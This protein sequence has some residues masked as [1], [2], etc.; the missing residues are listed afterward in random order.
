MLNSDRLDPFCRRERQFDRYVFR[1]IRFAVSK[2]WTGHRPHSE[3]NESQ[4]KLDGFGLN[5]VSL[6]LK[7]FFRSVKAGD[8]LLPKA[9]CEQGDRGK[10]KTKRTVLSKIK[11]L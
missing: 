3:S 9:F 11:R 7:G 1:R 10:W 6:D 5:L 8:G 4:P 2:I